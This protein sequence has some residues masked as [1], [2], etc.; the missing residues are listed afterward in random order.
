[1][2]ELDT[3][4]AAARDITKNEREA[5]YESKGLYLYTDQ[6]GTILF[7][8]LR[9]DHPNGHKWIRPLSRNSASDWTELK[10]PI[11]SDGKPLYNL[12]SIVK[13]SDKPVF[14][15]EGEKCADALIKLGL[16][17]TTSGGASS[18]KDADWQILSGR[19]VIIWADN[20]QAGKQYASDVQAKMI[21]LNAKV[22][23][24]DIEKLNLPAKSDCV[25]WLQQF[26][27]QHGHN[28]TKFDIEGLVLKSDAIQNPSCDYSKPFDTN[29]SA[30]NYN[31]SVNLECAANI[32][33][34]PI[35]WLWNGWLAKGKLHIFAG[36]AGTGKTTIAIALASTITLGDRFPD[37][38][39]SPLGSVL[40]W[41]GE[42]STKDTLVPR[43][44]AAGADLNKVHFV[45]DTTANDGLRG[46]DP[47]TDMH[48]LM[49]KAAGIADL[50][51]LIV[52]PI[53]NAVAG[54]S[55]K[56]GEVR[57]S[58]QPIVE[59][60]EK[61]NCAVLG[62][63]H[64]SKGGQGKDPL[65]R[66]TGSLAFGALA[67]IVL[68]TAKIDDGEN[69]KRIICRAKSNIGAD[70][71]GFEYE[72]L[73]KEVKSEILSSHIVW[74]AP[75]EGSARDLLAKPDNREYG[76]NGNS[77]L[78]EAKDFLIELLSQ[79]SLPQKQIQ[80]DAKSAG[81]S[82]S[83]L[84]R[85]KKALTIRSKKESDGWYWRLENNNAKLDQECQECH[86]NS[87]ALLAH[88][89]E[90]EPVNDNVVRV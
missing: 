51:L 12:H 29:I 65:E 6:D 53:V 28:A 2:N 9:M 36:Q 50:A 21:S 24:I 45:A 11:F 76:E 52:D 15:V 55:H 89:P 58:L 34:E 73:Q 35:S 33:P 16:L 4:K 38:S 22:K 40:I 63:T 20:D 1:M 17:A 84:K 43:L 82:W 88:L 46:F 30:R 44:M 71:G 61:L 39:K 83:T 59:F 10:E 64:F 86:T 60:A 69:S 77:A 25:D 87:M 66:V 70:T 74:G 7:V 8:R 81:H 72:L 14:I 80:K 42:D 62:I 85:A 13:Q 48:P 79:G 90:I 27:Q 56:N 68:A 67:R 19:E 32:T 41:S 54:D 26:D 18:A 78:E 3:I 47:A 37:G 49:D 23:Q 75:V 31:V 5:G 57:R